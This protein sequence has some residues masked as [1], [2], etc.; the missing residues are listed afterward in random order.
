MVL[1]IYGE[2]LVYQIV[3]RILKTY[4]LRKTKINLAA[5]FIYLNLLIYFFNKLGVELKNN[6]SYPYQILPAYNNVSGIP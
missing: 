4:Y 6:V 5:F 1:Y 2:W 3:Q